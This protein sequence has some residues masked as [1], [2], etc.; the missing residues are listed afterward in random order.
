MD[1][2]RYQYLLSKTYVY[3]LVFKYECRKCIGIFLQL[4]HQSLCYIYV[5]TWVE[6][7]KLSSSSLKMYHLM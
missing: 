6:C 1:I 3:R 2:S 7:N 5:N 4:L